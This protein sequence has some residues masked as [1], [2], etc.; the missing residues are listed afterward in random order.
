MHISINC[1]VNL[2]WK[3]YV[4]NLL[5]TCRNVYAVFIRLQNR[6]KLNVHPWNDIEWL[7]IRSIWTLWFNHHQPILS[8]LIRRRIHYTRIEVL[9]LLSL[10]FPHFSQ[11]SPGKSDHLHAHP[12][13]SGISFGKKIVPLKRGL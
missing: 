2:L 9:K 7:R 3:Y 8:L 5:R 1:Q 4:F 6:R 10:S 11:T 12:S 13:M